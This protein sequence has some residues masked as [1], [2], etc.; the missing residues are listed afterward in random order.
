MEDNFSSP[1][2]ICFIVGFFEFIIFSILLIIFSNVQVKP[3]EYVTHLDENNIDNYYAYINKLDLQEVMVFILCMLSR[4]IFI[5]FEYIIVDYFTPAHVILL[6]IIG[7]VSFLFI[8]DYDW[9]LYVKIVF[10]VFLVFFILIFVEIIELNIFGLQKNTKKN[11]SNRS[12]KE[13]PEYDYNLSRDSSA[14]DTDEEKK[15]GNTSET[16]MQSF[17]LNDEYDI[18]I[19]NK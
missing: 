2:E 14:N 5:L 9:K 15:S 19:G 16:D 13:E 7:E 1:Y 18:H 17:S 6:L 8:D 12:K 4:C 11:I 10:F 3:S